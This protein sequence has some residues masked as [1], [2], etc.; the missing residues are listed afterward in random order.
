MHIRKPRSI[1]NYKNDCKN[2]RRTK[3]GRCFENK[4]TCWNLTSLKKYQ[5]NESAS[6]FFFF[7]LIIFHHI[8]WQ[9]HFF[10]PVW[11][12]FTTCTHLRFNQNSFCMWILPFPWNMFPYLILWE[13]SVQ[14]RGQLL[15][16]HSL[17]IYISKIYL[18]PLCLPF[19]LRLK[20]NQGL[21]SRIGW[22]LDKIQPKTLP[23]VD[24]NC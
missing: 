18:Y 9:S 10:F 21:G 2:H 7:F 6:L 5:R 15:T 24:P 12:H 17:I 1:A 4:T 22:V 16:Y 23:S 11:L 3:S 14:K 13:N 8:S 20:I 19:P